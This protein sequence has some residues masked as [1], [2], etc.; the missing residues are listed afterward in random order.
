M[1]GHCGSADYRPPQNACFGPVHG[2]FAASTRF[3]SVGATRDETRRVVVTEP[4]CEDTGRK[5]RRVTKIREIDDSENG[6]KIIDFNRKSID[7]DL[8][9]KTY[10]GYNLC[11]AD[12]PEFQWCIFWYE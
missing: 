11:Q 1:W 6:T 8:T 12:V 9:H 4:T 5:T 10:R 2:L 3:A 7:S